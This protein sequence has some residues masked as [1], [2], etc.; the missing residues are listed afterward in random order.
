M[1]GRLEICG[2]LDE[3]G[4]QLSA[5]QLKL[6]AEL[7]ALLGDPAP[8]FLNQILEQ[9]QLRCQSFEGVFGLYSPLKCIP[10]L[11]AV[12]Q[13]MVVVSLD[14]LP[15]KESVHD[16]FF[17][18]HHSVCQRGHRS[19]V[20]LPPD[21]SDLLDLV[22]EGSHPILHGVLL[23]HIHLYVFIEVIFLVTSGAQTVIE[24][25]N[26]LSSFH[27]NHLLAFLTVDAQAVVPCL[28]E[29]L[30]IVAVCAQ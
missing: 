16:H 22:A 15:Q 8:V 2:S 20:G 13:K 5:A 21:L 18:V 6:T 4:S 19:L 30:A 17:N 7:L 9:D 24:L 23:A 11:V 12:P 3:G 26:A 27:E 10:L 14:S 29:L 28:E 1:K 25:A